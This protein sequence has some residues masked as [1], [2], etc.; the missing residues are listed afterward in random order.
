M[1]QE[2]KACCEEISGLI[3]EYIDNELDITTAELV[4]RHIG[5]CADCR[6]LYSDM[7]T[8]CRAAADSAYEAPLELHDRV[9]CAVKNSKVGKARR[10]NIK[11]ISTYFGIGIAAMLC[12]SIGATTIFK[13]LANDTDTATLG[14]S[15]KYT[16]TG[17][18]ARSTPSNSFI[19]TNSGYD[20]DKLYS[21]QLQIADST[22]TTESAGGTNE[23]KVDESIETKGNQP[24]TTDTSTETRAASTSE[25]TCSPCSTSGQNIDYTAGNSMI[26]LVGEWN[27]TDINGNKIVIVFYNSTD[28][29]LTD[30]TGRIT[31]G[32]YQV[33]ETIIAFIY[34]GISSEYRY[35]LCSNELSLTHLSGEGFI[36]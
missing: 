28:F 7:I 30:T 26:S 19:F 27:L 15:E 11:R 17:D 24:V 20:C 29:K 9:M 10:F 34:D 12:I 18:A 4:S 13:L 5:E 8:V 35:Y 22:A 1:E 36:K 21:S 23:D 32:T 3:I 25:T 33:T 14:T 2:R 31:T 16:L 6:K